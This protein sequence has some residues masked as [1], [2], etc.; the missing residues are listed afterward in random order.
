MDATNDDLDDVVRA[1]F[2][3]LAFKKEYNISS[4]N[5]INI[6]RIILQTVSIHVESVLIWLGTLLLQ[7]FHCQ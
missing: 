6:V 3:D 7:L 5:S 1:V 2:N 4:L